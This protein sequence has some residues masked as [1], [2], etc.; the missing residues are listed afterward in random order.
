[1][2]KFE[3]GQT[4]RFYLTDKWLY[5][6]IKTIGWKWYHITYTKSGT[7]RMAYVLVNNANTDIAEI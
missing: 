3:E 2:N 6:I 5:G 1:M 4:V 7:K